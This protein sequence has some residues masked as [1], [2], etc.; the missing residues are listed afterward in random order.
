MSDTR[1]MEE[2]FEKLFSAYQR[3]EDAARGF[4]LEAAC[5]PGC[6]DC[7]IDVGRMDMTTLEGLNVLSA[8]EGLEPP[9]QKRLRK[10]LLRDKKKRGKGSRVRCAFL[11]QRDLCL[12]YEQRPFSCRQLY[13]VKR[14]DRGPPTVHRA[15][16][17][18]S[19][20]FIDE[21]K[22]IDDTGLYGH[23]PNV[24]ALLMEPD[25]REMYLARSLTRAR[26]ESWAKRYGLR[27]SAAP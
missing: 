2:R 8:L 24:L 15:A 7:C 10:R 22:G 14:C 11:D 13:S 3:F 25:F 1:K 5:R 20:S 16:H 23:L 6:A 27:L 21:I 9:V 12:V 19:R 26:A 18:L 4:L 17:A